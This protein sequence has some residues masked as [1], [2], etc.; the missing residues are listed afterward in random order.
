MKPLV[1]GFGNTLRGDDGVGVAV[2]ESLRNS[3][4]D[5]VACHQLTPEL[6]EKISRASL[7][8]FVDCD[9]ELAPGEVRLAKLDTEGAFAG[10]L[11]HHFDPTALLRLARELYGAA[12][13][14]YVLG[15]GPE[16]CELSET[17]SPAAE[18]GA[19]K[20]AGLIREMIKP[21]LRPR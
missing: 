16:S 3:E 9:A 8:V 20:A 1:I 21:S 13:E 5:V 14:A 4:A 11:I 19:A 2:A 7:A 18:S 15:I 17:L 12:P 6:A 10:A